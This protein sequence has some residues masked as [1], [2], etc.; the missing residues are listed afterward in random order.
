MNKHFKMIN[1]S[2]TLLEKE[3]YGLKEDDLGFEFELKRPSVLATL[4]WALGIF[5]VALR[6]YGILAWRGWIE[7]TEGA[8]LVFVAFTC[9]LNAMATGF[10]IDMHSMQ[11]KGL[12][13][14]LRR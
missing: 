4:L 10:L 12:R 7:S 3:V 1:H 8:L 11:Y 14:G 2:E 9:G 5:M 6:V 13:I